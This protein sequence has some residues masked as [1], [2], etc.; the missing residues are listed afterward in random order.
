MTKLYGNIYLNPNDEAT[1]DN[2]QSILEGF[3]RDYQRLFDACG[4]EGGVSL[5]DEM[6]NEQFQS[7]CEAWLNAN[8]ATSDE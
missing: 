7:A 6:T 1:P 3:D 5:T 4:S 8:P 2:Q